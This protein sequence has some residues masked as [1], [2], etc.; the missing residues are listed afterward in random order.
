VLRYVLV[1]WSFHDSMRCDDGFLSGAATAP[2]H[3]YALGIQSIVRRMQEME[4]NRGA[5]LDS[6]TGETPQ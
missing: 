1:L 2:R 4:T 5:A 6:D 3:C